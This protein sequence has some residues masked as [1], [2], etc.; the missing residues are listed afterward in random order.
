M[1]TNLQDIISI[2]KS[3][4]I[5]PSWLWINSIWM[6]FSKR[7]ALGCL[8]EFCTGT[9]WLPHR[10]ILHDKSSALIK[11]N[12]RSFTWHGMV[13]AGIIRILLYG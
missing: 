6:I 10:N 7:N 2:F 4:T 12:P 9:P 3:D 11:R 1:L 13:F 5:S 8:F